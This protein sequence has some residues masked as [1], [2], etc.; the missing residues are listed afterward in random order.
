MKKMRPKSKKILISITGVFL[1]LVMIIG[2]STGLFAQA[3]EAE[4]ISDSATSFAAASQEEAVVAPIEGEVATSEAISSGISTSE[5]ASSAVSSEDF[6]TAGEVPETDAVEEP[7]AFAGEDSP[8]TVQVKADNTSFQ[9]YKNTTLNTMPPDLNV[10]LTINFTKTNIENGRIEIPYNFIPNGTGKFE[11]FT[12]TAPIFSLQTPPAPA[13]NSIVKNYDTSQADKL[14]INLNTFNSIKSETIN[15]VYKFNTTNYLTQIDWD[16]DGQPDLFGKIPNDF[17]LWSIAPE[18]YDNTGLV[19][20]G[21]TIDV[22]SN[23]TTSITMGTSSGTYVSGLLSVPVQFFSGNYFQWDLD[24]SYANYLYV[25]IPVGAVS[26]PLEWDFIGYYTPQSGVVTDAEGNQYVRYT[27]PLKNTSYAASPTEGWVHWHYGGNTNNTQQITGASFFPPAGSSEINVRIGV[28]YKPYNAKAI[29]ENDSYMQVANYKRGA[30]T[31]WSVN[32]TTR[33]MAPDGSGNPVVYQEGGQPNI[34]IWA[35]YYEYGNGYTFQNTGANDILQTRQTL[36]EVGDANNASAH[37]NFKEIRLYVSRDTA[38]TGDIPAWTQ[39]KVDYTVTNAL[40]DTEKTVSATEVGTGSAIIDPGTMGSDWATGWDGTTQRLRNMNLT[41]PTRENGELNANEYISKITVIPMG[42]SGADEGHFSSRNGFAIC[43]VPN[44]WANQIWPDGTSSN[45]ATIAWSSQRIYLNEADATNPQMNTTQLGNIPIIFASSSAASATATLVPL[46]NANTPGNQVTYRLEATN[47]SHNGARTWANPQIVIKVPK[48]AILDMSSPYTLTDVNGATA[49]LVVE[50]LTNTAANSDTE[51]NYYSFVANGYTAPVTNGSATFS[52]PLKFTIDSDI[53]K[54]TAGTYAMGAVITSSAN[55]STFSQ[56]GQAVNNIASA[57]ALKYGFDIAA[58]AK[59]TATTSTAQLIVSSVSNVDGTTAVNG[60][61]T[62]GLWVENDS[63]NNLI[64]ATNGEKIKMK[65]TIKNTGNTTFNNI[66]LYDI[67]PFS[68]DA[69]NSSGNISFVGIDNSEYDTTGI[70]VN[71]T[72]DAPSSLT[73]YAGLDLGTATLN[74]TWSTAAPSESN[75]ATAIDVDFGGKTIA[76]NESLSVVLIFSVPNSSVPQVARNQFVFSVQEGS[77]APTSFTSMAAGFSTEVISLTF[78]ENKPVNDLTASEAV[79]NM[80][81]AQNGVLNIGTNKFTIPA[82]KP[83]LTGYKFD[84]WQETPTGGTVYPADG[85]AVF[86]YTTSETKTMYAKWEPLP[87]KIT[88]A[89]NAGLLSGNFG[90]INADYATKIAQTDIDALSINRTGYTFMGWNTAKNG[91]GATYTADDFVTGD[92]TVY[93]QWQLIYSVTASDF[94]VAIADVTGLVDPNIVTR[95]AAKGKSEENANEPLVVQQSIQATIGSYD[96]TFIVG[97]GQPGEERITVKANVYDGD[98][99]TSTVQEVIQANNFQMTVAEAQTIGADGAQYSAKAGANAWEVANNKPVVPITADISKVN[100]MVAGTY[101]VTYATPSGTKVVGFVTLTDGDEYTYDKSANKEAIQASDFTA[102]VSEVAGL[103]KAAYIANAKAGAWATDSVATPDPSLVTK[104]DFSKVQS[105]SGSYPVV[106]E[107]TKG[108]KTTALVHVHDDGTS[109]VPDRQKKEAIQAKN[110]AVNLEDVPSLTNASIIS[111]AQAKAWEWDT[112][113]VNTPITSLTVTVNNGIAITDKGF[114]P[115]TFATPNGTSITVQMNVQSKDHISGDIGANDFTVALNKV[116]DLDN[117]AY[118]EKSEVKATQLNASG[119]NVDI[120]YSQITVVSSVVAAEGTYPVV[121]TATPTG[122]TVTVFVTVTDHHHAGT[123]AKKA[124]AILAND[125]TVTLSEAATLSQNSYKDKADVVAWGW[126]VDNIPAGTTAIARASVTVAPQ[127]LDTTK[128]GSYIITYTTPNGTSVD[129]L[130]HIVKGNANVPEPDPNVPIPDSTKIV[131]QADTFYVNLA[132]EKLTSLTEPEYLIRS[133]AKAWKANGTNGFVA[134]TKAD[135]TG[136]VN[137]EGTYPVVYSTATGEKVTAYVVAYNGGNPSP[138]PEDPTIREVIVAGDFSMKLSE[139]GTLNSTLYLQKANAR[140]WKW[141]ANG[142]NIPIPSS[143]L[144][145]DSASVDTTRIGTF[146]VKYS[147]ISSGIETTAMVTFSDADHHKVDPAGVALQA[148]DIILDK[149]EVGTLL[150]TDYISR[151]KAKAW[152]TE[153]N[154]AVNVTSADFSLVKADKG[155]YPVVYSTAT[156][157]SVVA[158][159]IVKDQEEINKNSEAREAIQGSDFVLTPSE[160]SALTSATS[161]DFYIT[162]GKV[163]AWSWTLAGISTPIPSTSL[164]VDA[165]KVQGAAGTYPVKY[166]TPANVTITLYATVKTKDEITVDKVTKEVIQANDFTVKKHEVSALIESD[167]L[168]KSKAEAWSIDVALNTVN[169]PVTVTKADFR[170]VKPVI[171]KYD[172]I[173]E[174]ANGTK[175]TA[176]LNV[177]DNNKTIIT[178]DGNGANVEANPKEIIIEEPNTTLGSLP[179]N[180]LRTGYTFRG[181]STIPGGTTPNVAVGDTFGGDTT[182][183]AIWDINSY[184][185]SFDT[186]G[187]GANPSLQTLQ[188]NTLAQKPS[189]EPAKKGHSFIGWFTA[190]V[191][192]SYWDFSVNTMPASDTTLYAQYDVNKYAVTFDLNGAGSGFYQTVNYGTEIQKPTDPKLYGY[193]FLGWFDENGNSWNF[194][195]LMPD[196]DITLV[197]HWEHTKY[198]LTY[199]TYDLQVISTKVQYAGDRVDYVEPSRIGGHTFARW[200][201]S[202]TTSK[203][204]FF[205]SMPDRD[206]TLVATYDKNAEVLPSS[207][208]ASKPVVTNSTKPSSKTSSSQTSTSSQSNTDAEVSIASSVASEVSSASISSS[209]PSSLVGS[210]ASSSAGNVLDTVATNTTWSLL[211]LILTVI[212][213]IVSIILLILGIKPHKKAIKR[214]LSFIGAAVGVVALVVFIIVTDFSGS[215]VFFDSKSIIFI[216]SLLMQMVLW[217]VA[218]GKK[219]ENQDEQNDLD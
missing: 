32:D 176:A 199:L 22:V 197:A 49:N 98:N 56:T 118:I 12:D 2:S 45:N 52:V 35:T 95:A 14:I 123:N 146:K 149:T 79:G 110:Y 192:G 207:S 119:Q 182:V 179:A 134:V 128:V 135:F 105:I 73:Q 152:K 191:E 25:D 185:L 15:L 181:W 180:P 11:D 203:W 3:S 54:A 160:I 93:A 94:D 195:T 55:S 202:G 126:D 205:N 133:S 42:T 173:Y 103:N 47:N 201:E 216:I 169:N 82:Q 8:I 34:P 143:D 74:G 109:V 157:E 165:S 122:D 17:V 215:M 83:T 124:E 196:N 136:V 108:T 88:F 65:L 80:P 154:S 5:A 150:N 60:S 194:A 188:Y 178:F 142:T 16:N 138:V 115:V 193:T 86:T 78:D 69:N 117:A 85:T 218:F 159:A 120:P 48:I 20:T 167:Y 132:K 4:S 158:F 141:Q 87:Y 62:N 41:F 101:E 38:D 145:V 213:M 70:T 21:D 53:T 99:H 9:T 177:I 77:K 209:A 156:G 189:L 168:T 211:S 36:Y 23:G 97:Q 147:I 33:I 206:L 39:Y 68:G 113:F 81:S 40:L 19:D 29:G 130:M 51:Y 210:V 66:R 26:N 44:S 27:R 111:K 148:N 161:N 104:V 72:Q 204:S 139:A 7:S 43:A 13:A 107:T 174:T 76:P 131:I 155:T 144:S 187:G 217:I 46:T 112:N 163:S 140:A 214:V 63:Q 18:A 208:S 31:A 166:T 114:Y 71:Y 67:L 61:A 190:P 200:V 162:K 127:S 59:Y 183:F 175:V 219:D 212:G 90:V 84:G 28:V 58:G 50:K 96:V 64:A 102:T 89:K 121:Y 153:D 37:S 172:V 30:R 100:T 116:G 1:V 171:G 24:P 170:D 164:L 106:Y 75:H 125:F 186:Q 184:D 129:A 91:N 6:S 151:S 92:L 198:T 137:A 57:E 10:S